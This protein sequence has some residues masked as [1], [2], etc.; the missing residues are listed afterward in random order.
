[1]VSEI[2]HSLFGY[3]LLRIKR[4]NHTVCNEY[5]YPG[6]MNVR[7]NSLAQMFYE[8]MS[9]YICCCK[10]PTNK[11]PNI[12]KY[13]QIYSNIFKYIQRYS[14]IFKDAKNVNCVII[15]QILGSWSNLSIV[16]FLSWP[17]RDQSPPPRCPGSGSAPKNCSAF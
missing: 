4:T 13:S 14:N 1:M 16:L 9:Q 10:L 11:Y 2:F 6:R 8:W 7:I 15:N 12:F 3:R 5:F 17:H